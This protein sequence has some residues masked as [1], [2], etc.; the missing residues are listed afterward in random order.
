LTVQGSDQAYN[1]LINGK[2]T[3]IYGIPFLGVPY[4]ENKFSV[5]VE[6]DG[7]DDDGRTKWK[8][9]ETDFTEPHMIVFHNKIFPFKFQSPLFSAE[10]IQGVWRYI[11]T[12]MEYYSTLDDLKQ[13]DKKGNDAYILPRFCKGFN[14]NITQAKE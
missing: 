12:H 1:D 8:E 7:N 10:K 2:L 4:M 14:F 9:I 5:S 3:T 11:F 13:K 6:E